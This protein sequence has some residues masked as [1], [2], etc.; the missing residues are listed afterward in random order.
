MPLLQNLISGIKALFNKEQR[1]RDMDEELRAFQEASPKK[2]FATASTLTKPS[3]PPAS[4]WAASN[5]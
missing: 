1:S 4:R 5:P 3:A 2:K